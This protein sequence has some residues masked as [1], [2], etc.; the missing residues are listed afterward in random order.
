MKTFFALLLVIG[1]LASYMVLAL[2]FGVFQ[3]YPVVQYLI[4]LA[5]IAWLVVL[6]RQRFTWRRVAALSF[7][8]LLTAG[9]AYWTLIGSEY[10]RREHRAKGG[11]VLAE[12]PSL[13][14]LNAAGS[15]TR[16][17]T[18][19]ERATLLVFYRGYW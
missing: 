1:A 15:P 12:L 8:V 11:E 3:Y 16:L 9:F 14:L 2:A 13:E 4:A 17:F 6:L 7:A 10:E 19:G 5:G 18:G